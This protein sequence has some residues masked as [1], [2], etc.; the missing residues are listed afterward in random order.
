MKYRRRIILF[1]FACA[2]ILLAAYSLT[3]LTVNY[4]YLNYSQSEQFY[5]NAGTTEYTELTIEELIRSS[6]RIS[7]ELR[8]KKGSLVNVETS[9][10]SGDIDI[11]VVLL[12]HMNESSEEV[13]GYSVTEGSS[14]EQFLNEC[15]I[16]DVPLETLILTRYP[17]A[18]LL[19]IPRVGSGSIE[20]RYTVLQPV[21]EFVYICLLSIIIGLSFF[22]KGFLHLIKEISK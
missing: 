20:L 1:G 10:I 22:L 12:V 18:E 7:I 21:P 3:F 15:K 17:F 11:D 6:R 8:V 9:L 2:F 4:K 19:V 5:V 16:N 14:E 13:I